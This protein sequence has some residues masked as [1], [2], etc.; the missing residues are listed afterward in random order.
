MKMEPMIETARMAAM[1][2][3]EVLMRYWRGAAGGGERVGFDAKKD[4]SPVTAADREAEA[5]IREVIRT[6][7]PDHRILGEEDTPEGPERSPY[8]WVIDPIDAT[9]QFVRGLPAFGTLIALFVEG[10]VAVALTNAPALGETV[11]AARGRGAFVNDRPLQVSAV[12]RIDEAFVVHGWTSLFADAGRL[13]NLAGLCRRAWGEQG[14][15]DF[16]SYVQLAEGHVDA[17]L[18]ADA[19]IWDLAAVSLIVEEA[20]GR[21]TDFDGHALSFDTRSMVATNGHLHDRILDSFRV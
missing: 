6:R 3:A 20:G 9:K 12:K 4:T 13:D 10:R 7:H 2:A 5:A 14:F 21:V 18:E 16:H 17:V 19:E 11:T 15:Q 8:A 1:R